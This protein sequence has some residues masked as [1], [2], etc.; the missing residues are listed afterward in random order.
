M[1]SWLIWIV[2]GLILIFIEIFA[3]KFIFL[4]IG[5]SAVI[6]GII[7]ILGIKNLIVLLIIFLIIVCLNILFLR[8]LITKYLIH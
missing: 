8:K 7:N 4:S 5:I 2:I 3:H 1:L 6:T